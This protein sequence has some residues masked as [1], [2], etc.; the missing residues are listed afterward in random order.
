MLNN[1]LQFP[2]ACIFCHKQQW[3][4]HSQKTNLHFPLAALTAE[5]LWNLISSEGTAGPAG[6]LDACYKQEEKMALGTGAKKQ[7][8]KLHVACRKHQ[9]TRARARTDAHTRTLSRT[10][11]HPRPTSLLTWPFACSTSPSFKRTPVKNQKWNPGMFSFENSSLVPFSYGR[12]IGF[13]WF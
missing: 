11:T 3:H 1:L 6:H 13:I 7:P 10:R 8:G 2:R 4:S 12:K 5:V 9:G